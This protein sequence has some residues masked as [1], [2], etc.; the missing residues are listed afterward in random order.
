MSN[1]Q[2]QVKLLPRLARQYA[3]RELPAWG[4]VLDAIGIKDASRWQNAGHIKA[5]GK[6]HNYELDLDLANWSDRF[7]YFVGR[8]SDLP[9]QLALRTLLAPGETLVDIGANI[10][11]M[12]LLGASAVGKSGRVIS[13]EPNP[14]VVSRLR[15]NVRDNNLS[16]VTIHDCAL[17]EQDAVMQ[18]SVVDNACGCGTLRT[19]DQREQ[20][21][22]TQQA[23]VQVKVGDKVLSEFIAAHKK[24]PSPTTLKIDVEGYEIHALSGLTNFFEVV[25]PAVLFEADDAYLK[26][27]GGSS[28]ELLEFFWSKG[29]TTGE[30]DLAKAGLGNYNL[31]ITPVTNV[32][33]KAHANMVAWKP[34]SPHSTRLSQYL[35]TR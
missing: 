7:V 11:L 15:A 24:T 12:T 14:V 22:V 34:D 28:R 23:S 31:T 19:L 25:Q 10:G 32:P 2:A 29:Y 17:A 6:W 4:R 13:F 30:L 21:N 5:R 16:W 27:A 18:L 35:Q 9:S 8:H 20:Q 3:R 1:P 33:T 26:N